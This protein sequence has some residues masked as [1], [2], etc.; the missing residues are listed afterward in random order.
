[1]AKCARRISSEPLYFVRVDRQGCEPITIP[2]DSFYDGRR[3]ISKRLIPTI[4][5]LCDLADVDWN[6]HVDHAKQYVNHHVVKD[7][8]PQISI[9]FG[10]Y[11]DGCFDGDVRGLITTRWGMVG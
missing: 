8:G 3:Y 1:M 7:G 2:F 5:E 11:F 6:V 9:T 10:L 4:N